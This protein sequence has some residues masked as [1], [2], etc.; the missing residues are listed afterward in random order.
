MVSR[1][2]QAGTKPAAEN[3]PFVG[4]KPT[5]PLN[6]AGTL[7]EPAVSVPSANDTS[8]AATA[9]ADPDEEPPEI[10]SGSQTLRGYPY[11]DLQPD[12]PAANWS[13]LVLPMN[14]APA[15]NK[16]STTVADFSGM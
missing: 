4:L 3:V 6:A 15:C 1:L 13:R 11:G 9:T 12:S 5:M 8:P 7:P 14:N 10:R 2:L 16:A